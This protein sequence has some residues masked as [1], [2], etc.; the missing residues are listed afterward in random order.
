[1]CP[2]PPSTFPTLVLLDTP[3][4]VCARRLSFFRICVYGSAQTAGR[5]RKVRTPRA[6]LP[7]VGL[8]PCGRAALPVHHDGA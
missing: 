1:V 2:L 7:H 6:Q 5:L 3:A 4:P 8:Q